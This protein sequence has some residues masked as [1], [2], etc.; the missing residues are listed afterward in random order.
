M[1]A[2]LFK[3]AGKVV[4]MPSMTEE[5]VMEEQEKLKTRSIDEEI[6]GDTVGILRISEDMQVAERNYVIDLT[7]Q[8]SLT[9]FQSRA[10][11]ALRSI[12]NPDTVIYLYTAKGLISIGKGDSLKLV[13]TIPLLT[14]NILDDGV[15]IY[16]DY[17]KGAKLR[18]VR[19][20]DITQLRLNL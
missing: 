19:G 2:G 5:S 13:K 7:N 12:E 8:E 16:K 4:M 11:K 9:E 6:S 15:K 1:D 14:D 10:L 18:E 20:T 3:D 17:K